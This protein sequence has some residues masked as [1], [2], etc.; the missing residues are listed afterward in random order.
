M[1]DKITKPGIVSR[2]T[3][4]EKQ[5]T[6]LALVERLE[7]EGFTVAW[8]DNVEGD[9]EGGYLA[10]KLDLKIIGLLEENENTHSWEIITYGKK[11]L[12]AFNALELDDLI[13]WAWGEDSEFI[14][15]ALLA[16]GQN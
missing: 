13:V 11:S 9:G 15:L 14:G 10:V 4:K 6:F 12:D 1:A 2:Y 3:G 7:L 5:W 8:M 16:P